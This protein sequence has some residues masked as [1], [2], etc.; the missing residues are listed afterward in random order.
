[1]HFDGTCFYCGKFDPPSKFHHNAS[2][3]LESRSYITDVCVI[4]GNENEY[5]DNSQRE[6]IWETYIKSAFSH[7]IKIESHPNKSSLRVV[8]DKLKENPSLKCYI[9]LDEHTAKSEIMEH[10]FSEFPNYMPEILPSQFDGESQSMIEC[11]LEGNRD[12]FYEF[13]PETLS[14]ENKLKCWSLLRDQGT[15]KEDLVSKK[16][17]DNVFKEIKL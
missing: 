1:M 10:K 2:K 7:K 4:L 14:E 9:A 8:L 12:A 17:W 5:L 13:L 3:F 15:V 11:I 6:Q 16:W